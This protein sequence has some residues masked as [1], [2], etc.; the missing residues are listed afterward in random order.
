[1]FVSSAGPKVSEGGVLD[2][3][4]FGQVWVPPGVALLGDSLG[5][6]ANPERPQDQVV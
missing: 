5:R 1:M 2:S 6:C 4:H 3:A